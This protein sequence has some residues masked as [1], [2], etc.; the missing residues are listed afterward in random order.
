MVGSPVRIGAP[1]PWML[2]L[3]A[4][5]LTGIVIS[6]MV[7]HD[8]AGE[9][10][11]RLATLGSAA[12]LVLAHTRNYMLCRSRSCRKDADWDRGGLGRAVSASIQNALSQR[13]ETR[14]EARSI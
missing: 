10:G 4:L 8:L 12:L 9:R 13:K 6:G 14:E 2:L 5:G 1:V 3:G 11:E 7:L